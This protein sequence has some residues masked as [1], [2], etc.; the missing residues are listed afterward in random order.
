MLNMTNINNVNNIILNPLINTETNHGFELLRKYYDGQIF[1]YKPGLEVG[2]GSFY[3]KISHFILDFKL[4]S[5]LS[6]PTL[7]LTNSSVF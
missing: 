1:L 2:S 3:Y 4:L 7:P 5:L 6:L